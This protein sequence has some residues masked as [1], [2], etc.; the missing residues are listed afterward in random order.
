MFGNVQL[1]NSAKYIITNVSD[2][3]SELVVVGVVTGDE[4]VYTCIVQNIHGNDTDGA[5]LTV[6]CE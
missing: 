6:I 5:M 4:G 2:S 1:P 3:I